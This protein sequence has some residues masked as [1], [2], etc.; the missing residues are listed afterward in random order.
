MSYSNG[1]VDLSMSNMIIKNIKDDNKDVNEDYKKYLEE[2]LERVGFY[3]SNMRNN[4]NKDDKLRINFL[5]ERLEKIGSYLIG[6]ISE[7]RKIK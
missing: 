1:K 7:L 5:E 4:N 3:L 2:G 6:I